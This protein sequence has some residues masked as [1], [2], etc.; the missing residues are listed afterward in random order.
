MGTENYKLADYEDN[1]EMGTFNSAPINLKANRKMS[2]THSIRHQMMKTLNSEA[3]I[4][5]YVTKWENN[6][7]G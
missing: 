7:T 5:Y 4:E 1:T 3:Q 6:P 2:Y